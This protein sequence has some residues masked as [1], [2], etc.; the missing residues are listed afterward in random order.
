MKHLAIDIGAESGRGVVGEIVNNKL[1]LKEVHRFPNTPLQ[2]NRTLRWNTEQLLANIK[3]S[4]RNAGE[5]A[6]IGLDTWGV[7]FA[8][9]DHSKQLIEPPYC[10]RDSRTDGVMEK[11]FEKIPKADIYEQTGV[12]FMQI[13]SLFQLCATPNE[14]RSKASYFLPMPDYL[15]FALS[16]DQPMGA[17]FTI[18]TTTQCCNPRTG[19]WAYPLLEHL[20]LPTRIFPKVVSPGTKLGHVGKAVLIA[21]GCHDTAC[22]VAAVPAEGNDFAWISSGT[23]SI[24]GVENS[25][26]IINQ[27][28]FEA[29][30]TN[31][32]G[33]SNTF[34]VSKNVMGLW[35]VQQCR[36]T[37]AAQGMN[38][39]YEQLTEMAEKAEPNIAIFDVDH[40][41]CLKPCDMPKLI[42]KLISE[43]GKKTSED[44][45]Q[46]IRIVLE[47]LA[48]K[49]AEHLRA[50]EGITGRRLKRIHIVGGGS[51][52]KLLN[53]LTEEACQRPVI[54][55][56]AEA[57]AIGNI[58]MQMIAMGELGSV[59]NGRAMVREGLAP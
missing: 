11:V 39:T 40:P 18:A 20:E 3:Q 31:E 34:R 32:G 30:I 59:A 23:W 13:N 6:S 26:P 14:T 54:A 15:N 4:I 48:A 33:V 52:N 38:Y 37:W 56:P 28:A 53:R 45:G 43:R 29:N 57:T 51:Q 47:S 35:L 49:Y 41:Q 27:Q 2:L 46:I 17:E 36:A 10:Y 24:M 8:L 55:G 19:D 16:E 25:T 5:I 12:Q 42:I 22:A 7:D 44:P 50:L 21:P 1:Q 9:L 58:M